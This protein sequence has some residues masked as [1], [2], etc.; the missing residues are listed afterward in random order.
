MT[1]NPP[2]DRRNVTVATVASGSSRSNTRVNGN[3]LELPIIL[4]A[5]LSAENATIDAFVTRLVQRSMWQ[6]EA[7]PCDD[8][9]VAIQAFIAGE[10]LRS[11]IRIGRSIWY[12]HPHDTIHIYGCAFPVAAM[13]AQDVALTAILRHPVLDP[14]PIRVLAVRE[15]NPAKIG[16]GISIHVEVPTVSVDATPIPRT[17]DRRPSGIR[18]A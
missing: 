4:V 6:D 5:A 14:L 11:L 12:Q 16:L 15:M 8:E 9:K 1:S 10:R 3:V 17:E 18:T 7:V 2:P 13:C